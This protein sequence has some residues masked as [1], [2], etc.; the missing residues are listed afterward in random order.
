MALDHEYAL[1]GGFNR[2]HVG[3]WMQQVA[4]LVSA[5]AVFLLLTLVD[6]AHTFGVDAKLPPVVLAAF[7]AGAVY[8]ALYFVFEKWLWKLGP[9]GRLL[10]VPNLAG[11]WSCEGLGKDQ[12]PPRPWSGTAT[13]VQSWDRIRVHLQTAQSSSDSVAAALIHDAAA[14]H[15]L[16]YHYRNHPRIGEREL[17]AHH[18]FAELTFAADG[19]FATGEYF[20]GRG[21]NTFGTMTLER[22]DG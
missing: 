8:A 6:L 9:L 22:E 21:R 10:N 20:N 1:V 17:S 4:A 7:G 11:K 18:G 15:R 16:M 2:S 13:I 14:G 5:A 19:R 3:R 12:D